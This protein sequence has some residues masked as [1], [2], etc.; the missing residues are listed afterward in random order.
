MYS[1]TSK[2]YEYQGM[3]WKIQSAP[4][5]CYTPM[6]SSICQLFFNM[7]SYHARLLV[8]R[9]DLRQP[10]FT[11]C[12]QRITRFFRRLNRRLIAKY[13]LQQLGY[14]WTREQDSAKA[15]H[16][17]CVL[18]IDGKCVNYP[19][20]VSA[21]CEEVWTNMSG[22][23][24]RP[25][26]C[27]YLSH[28]HNHQIIGEVIYRLSYLAK[29]RGKDKKSPQTKNYGSSRIAANPKSVSPLKDMTRAH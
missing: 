19:S 23:Y 15:Q 7:H 17:H 24:W 28:R 13:K 8:F 3:F 9:F 18:F 27:F 26:N 6:L 21:M 1:T 22:S 10:S 12:N 5:G 16:Y 20:T 11:D 4:S 25:D 29:T 14:F 2:Y